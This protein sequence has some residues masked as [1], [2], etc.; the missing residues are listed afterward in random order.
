[1]YLPMRSR[2]TA[3]VSVCLLLAAMVE[4]LHL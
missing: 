1:W 4:A 2:L 3:V